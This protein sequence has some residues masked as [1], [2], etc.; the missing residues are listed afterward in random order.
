MPI[1][2]EFRIPNDEGEADT[3]EGTNSA[4][5]MT[6]ENEREEKEE[7]STSTG[8]DGGKG[9]SSG[10]GSGS[11]SG[12]YNAD[13]S[14][15]ETSS[16]NDAASRVPKIK[17]PDDSGPQIGNESGKEEDT[18][19][20]KTN[21]ASHNTT[22][23]GIGLQDVS[24]TISRRQSSGGRGTSRSRNSLR[25]EKTM[26]VLNDSHRQKDEKAVKELSTCLAQWNGIRIEHPMDP[27]IDLST[28]GFKIGAAHHA[29]FVPNK[30]GDNNVPT[31]NETIM[32][33]KLYP[34]SATSE[35]HIP[36]VEQ[37]TKLLEVSVE[38]AECNSASCESLAHFF[39][40]LNI[41]INQTPK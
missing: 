39:H 12:G 22:K 30:N 18:V 35:S 1:D 37:Y 7:S 11:G 8:S 17:S 2:E 3:K 4:I 23:D 24:T 5:Q 29:P 9:N 34:S 40:S 41:I 14:S 31:P 20:L 25:S 15:S 36:S 16:N 10:S 38:G 21:V 28:V 26:D 6:I 32:Q 27:R 33:T 13:C 19:A